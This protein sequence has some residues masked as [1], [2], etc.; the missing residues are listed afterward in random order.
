MS[1]YARQLSSSGETRMRS[2]LALSM[3]AMVTVVSLTGC[4]DLVTADIHT[5]RGSD[6]I[7]PTLLGEVEQGHEA[8]LITIDVI[9]H[10][11]DDNLGPLH[12]VDINT[13]EILLTLPTPTPH[14]MVARYILDAETTERLGGP[15]WVLA[16]T[17][18]YLEYPDG[19][20]FMDMLA[21]WADH[22]RRAFDDGDIDDTTLA[23]C[24]ANLNSLGFPR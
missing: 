16:N 12:L 15:N 10:H 22:C 2:K 7:R 9:G 3:L 18:V 20:I 8:G 17:A 14:N 19:I 4:D 6:I 21:G 24:E 11:P 1:E 23:T 13:G 5:P